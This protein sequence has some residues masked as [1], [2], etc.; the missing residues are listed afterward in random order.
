[1][2]PI[3]E[4]ALE[5]RA[6]RAAK[7]VSLLLQKTRWKKESVDNRGGFQLVDPYYNTVVDGVRFDLTPQEVTEICNAKYEASLR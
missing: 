3:S 1:M 7:K 6:R 4:T 5:S 2:Y